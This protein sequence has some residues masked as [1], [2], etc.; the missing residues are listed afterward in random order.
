MEL[1]RELRAAQGGNQSSGPLSGEDYLQQGARALAQRQWEP[2]VQAYSKA[3][4]KDPAQPEAYLNRGV[5][6]WYLAQ[7]KNVFFTPQEAY[8]EAIADFT[9]AAALGG[10]SPAGGPLEG[11]EPVPQRRAEHHH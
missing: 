10:S 2:A 7:N 5:A 1:S 6:K 11:G 8:D 4:E 3:I 9:K